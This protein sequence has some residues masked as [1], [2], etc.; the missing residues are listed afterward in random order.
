MSLAP[1][2]EAASSNLVIVRRSSLQGA[3]LPLLIS[4]LLHWLVVLTIHAAALY[5]LLEGS[6]NICNSELSCIV[7]DFNIFSSREKRRVILTNKQ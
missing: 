6:T 1:T 2:R 5:A 7:D 4:R 3:T